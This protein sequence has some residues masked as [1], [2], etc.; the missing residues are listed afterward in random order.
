MSAALDLHPHQ[1]QRGLRPAFRDGTR[2][3]ACNHGA[4]WM[5]RLTAECGRCGTALA[6]APK[7][8]R[9]G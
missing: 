2:C 1:A 7:E 8:P 4:F 3:P 6:I 5:H 9:H